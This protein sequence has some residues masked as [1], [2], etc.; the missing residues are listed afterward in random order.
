ME[1]NEAKSKYLE[2]WGSLGSSWGVSRTMAQIHALLMIASTPLSTEEIMEELKISRGNVNMNIRALMDWGLADKVLVPGERKEYF[3][4][5][6]DPMKLAIQVAKERK[7][8]ELD[9][10]IKVLNELSNVETNSTEAIEFKKVSEDLLKFANQ[11]DSAIQM[12]VSSSDNW[13]L[14]LIGKLK[15]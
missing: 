1:L 12:F 4:T 2:A 11:A 5:D 6:K 14:K 10:I 15:F 9:P 7:K 3:K 8:R 13:F